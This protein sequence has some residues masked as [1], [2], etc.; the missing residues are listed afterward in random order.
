MSGVSPP[1]SVTPQPTIVS[2]VPAD[3]MLRS[4]APATLTGVLVDGF[5]SLSSETSEPEPSRYCGGIVTFETVASSPSPSFVPP[6]V[7]LMSGAGQ[8]IG[9]ATAAPVSELQ[10]PAV[11]TVSG[12]I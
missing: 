9:D 7:T 11:K 2:S 4:A 10:W 1:S 5:D 12:A 8:A 6:I 3:Q